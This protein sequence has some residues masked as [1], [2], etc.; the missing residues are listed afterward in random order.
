MKRTLIALVLALGATA[1]VADPTLN[2]AQN[3]QQSAWQ[4]APEATAYQGGGKIVE[5]YTPDY[6]FNP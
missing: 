6:S 5:S 3:Q 4:N 1:A 2:A